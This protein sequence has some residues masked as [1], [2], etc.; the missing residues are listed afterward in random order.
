MFA[1]GAAAL[2]LPPIFKAMP[3]I[4]PGSVAYDIWPRGWPTAWVVEIVAHL[5]MTHGLFPNGLLPDV[6]FSFLS[7]AWSLSTEWQFYVLALWLGRWRIGAEW[8]AVSF[9]VLA[10]A[11]LAWHMTAP[12]SW[13]FSRA[14]L[15]NK[16]E[17]FALG[18]ASGGWVDRR[19][20]R[21]VRDCSRRDPDPVRGKR[22]SPGNCCRR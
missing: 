5:T 1:L 10:V 21:L 2:S 19:S 15:P 7:A 20:K 11:G 13:Q 12:E 9:L 3:W 14:F 17:Y 4:A 18:I 16:A 22:R 8:L 6:W